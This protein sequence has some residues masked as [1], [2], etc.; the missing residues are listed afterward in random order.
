MTLYKFMTNSSSYEIIDT[1]SL[2]IIAS[3]NNDTFIVSNILDTVKEYSTSLPFT[4]SVAKTI[5]PYLKD[6]EMSVVIREKVDLSASGKNFTIIKNNLIL[7]VQTVH[8]LFYFTI[9]NI[10]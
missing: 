9:Q 10:Y 8:G 1:I 3:E 7:F 2:E 5:V 6:E 4:I